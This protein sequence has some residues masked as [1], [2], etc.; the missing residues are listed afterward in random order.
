MQMYE[1]ESCIRGYHHYRHLCKPPIGGKCICRRDPYNEY[2]RFAVDVISNFSKVGSVPRKFSELI[3]T[4]L[5][6]KDATLCCEVTGEEFVSRDLPQGGIELPCKYI[7]SGQR[8]DILLFKKNM[9]G[10]C[11]Y[12][13]ILLNHQT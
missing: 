10:M 2:D 4:F 11:L 3:S 1:L 9:E 8:R 12:K 5:K 13:I 7:F 6:L